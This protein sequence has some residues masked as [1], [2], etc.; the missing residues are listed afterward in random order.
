M[1]KEWMDSEE[2]LSVD[3]V[4]SQV[5]DDVSESLEGLEINANVISDKLQRLCE[6][7]KRQKLHKGGVVPAVELSTSAKKFVMDNIMYIDY[8]D[9]AALV[10]VKPETVKNALSDLGIKVPVQGARS[11]KEIDVGTF[12]TIDDCA[13]CQVQLEHSIFSVGIR[14]CRKCYEENIRNWAEEGETIRLRFF[15]EE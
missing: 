3:T 12:R 2:D 15:T 10:G 11:W 1:D 14:N 8:R 4:D 9:M 6:K 7:S 5:E 13:K